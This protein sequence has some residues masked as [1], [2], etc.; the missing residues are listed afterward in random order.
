MRDRAPVTHNRQEQIM[1]ITEEEIG[2]IDYVVVEFP[3]DCENFTGEMANELVRLTDNGTIRLLD[4]LI[5]SKDLDGSFEAFEVDDLD[6]VDELRTIA[7]EIAEILAAEDIAHLAAAVEP[8][9]TAGVIVYENSWAAPFASTA[10]RAGGQL[11]AAG[12]IPMQAI[13]ATLEED[14]RNEQASTESSEK[15]N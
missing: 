11:I 5:V 3:P 14:E 9:G 10:R 4:L 7:T 6:E 13:I 12:R 8:G 2:P 1:L 15:E